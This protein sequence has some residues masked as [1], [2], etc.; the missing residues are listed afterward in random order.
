MV[1]IMFDARESTTTNYKYELTL[2]IYDDHRV[3]YTFVFWLVLNYRIFNDNVS[4]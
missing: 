2:T 3:Q 1:Y 4:S